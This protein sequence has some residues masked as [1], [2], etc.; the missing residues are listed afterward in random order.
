MFITV[1]KAN[2][3]HRLALTMYHG[4]TNPANWGPLTRAY[5]DKVLGG[6]LGGRGQSRKAPN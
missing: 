2:G 4:G 5:P 1:F 3:D 6:P